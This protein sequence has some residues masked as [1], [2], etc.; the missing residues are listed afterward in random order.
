MDAVGLIPRAVVP[1]IIVFGKTAAGLRPEDAKSVKG[2]VDIHLG[3]LRL[4]QH[5]A[6]E[7]RVKA[8]PDDKQAKQV[9][10]LAARDAA[11]DDAAF[12]RGKGE[13]DPGG[14]KIVQTIAL[15]GQLFGVAVQKLKLYR[16]RAHRKQ[17]RVA[18]AY[19]IFGICPA[20]NAARP[21]KLKLQ[22]QHGRQTQKKE[23][24]GQRDGAGKN[25]GPRPGVVEDPEQPRRADQHGPEKQT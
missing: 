20:H 17:P 21:L 19:R 23:H 18:E 9:L 7:L 5:G 8:A 14:L 6:G 2:R 11:A 24:R 15:T 22:P 1:E 16:H 25:P 4:G 12:L 13:P 10:E 3:L